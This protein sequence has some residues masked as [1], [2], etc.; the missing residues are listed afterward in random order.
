M[1]GSIYQGA[2]SPPSLKFWLP[3]LTNQ[4]SF[5]LK[6]KKFLALGVGS[7][8]CST[9]VFKKNSHF[10]WVSGGFLERL[11]FL[12]RMGMVALD[13]QSLPP[14][15]KPKAQMDLHLLKSPGKHIKNSS[16]EI[17]S[18]LKPTGEHITYS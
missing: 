9:V 2:K 11:G 6:W 13:L 12:E 14:L 18:I 5:Q 8:F 16:S 7:P 17:D 3:S 15:R 1:L 4:S 10:P